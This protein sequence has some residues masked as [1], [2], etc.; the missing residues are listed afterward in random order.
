[1]YYHNV[2]AFPYIPW[3]YSGYSLMQSN[4]ELHF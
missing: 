2:R 4:L 1:M 3:E